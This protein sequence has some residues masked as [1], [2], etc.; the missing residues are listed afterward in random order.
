M[1]VLG[2]SNLRLKITMLVTLSQRD[3][4]SYPHG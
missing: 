2:L 1:F 4:N 3:N